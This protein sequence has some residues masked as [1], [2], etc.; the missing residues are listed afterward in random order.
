MYEEAGDDSD[1]PQCGEHAEPRDEETRKCQA[2]P[3][4]FMYA[5]SAAGSVRVSRR[6]ATMT[7]GRPASS[8]RVV[9]AWASPGPSVCA[10]RTVSPTAVNVGFVLRG[11]APA[12][13]R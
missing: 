7:T 13:V 2:G 10:P 1:D 11:A 6:R 9:E 3:K 12:V 8:S 5:G 4:G